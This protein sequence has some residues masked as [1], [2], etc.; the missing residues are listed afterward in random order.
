M[1]TAALLPLLLS[2]F[3]ALPVHAQDQKLKPIDAINKANPAI[4]DWKIIG[5]CK[6]G[7]LVQHWIPVAWTETAPSGQSF[8]EDVREVTEKT[9]V[10]RTAGL[11]SSSSARVFNFSNLLWK[12]S[13]IARAY[14]NRVCQISDA[15]VPGSVESFDTTDCP[16]ANTVLREIRKVA[17]LTP[18]IEEAYTSRADPG[19]TSGCR[20][21]A[22]IEESVRMQVRCD[23]EALSSHLQSPG[24]NATLLAAR[25]CIGKWGSL[26]PRQSRNIGL[27]SSEASAK[28]VLRAMSTSRDHLGVVPYLVDLQGKMQMASPHQSP[29]FL[30]GV[31]PL[32]PPADQ[33]P[34]DRKAGWIYWR[35][36][37]CCI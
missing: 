4:V 36:V 9:S 34:M 13:N 12:R 35:Q 28:S 5:T 31:H 3:T 37:R 10:L 18:D 25:N 8:I 27:F 2:L 33:L 7:E 29:G 24:T 11:E 14:N 17:L 26:Y 19:W 6:V 32:P 21:K 22:H 23:A 1:R 16:S 20:D 30:V 15:S